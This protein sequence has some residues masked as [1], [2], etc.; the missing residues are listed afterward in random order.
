MVRSR[1]LQ[2]LTPTRLRLDA[3]ERTDPTAS[4]RPAGR[5]GPGKNLA[6]ASW[7]AGSYLTSGGQRG[8]G[9]VRIAPTEL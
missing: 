9:R 7:P 8:S 2:V 4:N 3:P 5:A 6:Q 1:R